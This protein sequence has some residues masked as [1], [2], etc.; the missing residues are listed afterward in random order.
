MSLDVSAIAVTM[1]AAAKGVVGETWPATQTY[2]ESETKIFAERFASIA[3]LRADGLITE[4]R[5]KR[6]IRFQKES[7]ET[8]LL[9]VAGLNQIMVEEALNAALAAVSD[10]VNAA[11]GFA[12]L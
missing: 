9:A 5:A 11:M 4:F 10:V 3:K 7:W 1:L 8:M 2:F 12:L 6:H